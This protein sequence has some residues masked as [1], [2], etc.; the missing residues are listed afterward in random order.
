MLV[1][2][3]VLQP[4]ID[5]CDALL[6]LWHGVTGSWGVAIVLLAFTLQL[7]FL[8]VTLA[9]L[10][11]T[12]KFNSMQPE[13][14]QVGEKLRQLRETHK[15]DKDRFEQER[16]RLLK[17]HQ[18]SADWIQAKHLEGSPLFL[19]GFALLEIVLVLLALF[20]VLLGAA[21]LFDRDEFASDVGADEPDLLLPDLAEPLTGH[22]FVLAGAMALFIAI[23]FAQRAV[24]QPRDI[25]DRARRD[26]AWW[27]IS[28]S[29]AV[30]FGALFLVLPAAFV[31][32]ILALMGWGLGEKLALM[33][34]YGPARRLY[35]GRSERRAASGRA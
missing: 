2:A 28:L 19:L 20:A 25:E 31:L 17:E 11:S 32:F 35:I 12:E 30:A 33:R 10:N 5:V 22:P 9:H 15:D 13:L 6:Q 21:F 29:V 14:K 7:A 27:W 34:F 16:F 1:I 23:W 8:P 24:S 18:K 4:L 3:N 26:R